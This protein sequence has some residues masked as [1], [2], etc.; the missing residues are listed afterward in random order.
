MRRL[1]ELL[2]YF[3]PYRGR[4]AAGVAAILA[5]AALGLA[6]PALL[7]AAIDALASR[8]TGATLLAYGAILVGVAV[9][10]GVFS[11]LQRRIL[12]GVSRDIEYD[13]RND[14]F[15]HLERLDAD[16][17]R[18]N[19]IGD[20]MARSTSDLGA[21]RMLCG[22][23]IMYGTHTV[24]TAIGALAGMVWI[25]PPLTLVAVA[26]LPVVALV[27]QVFGERIHHLFETAQREFATLTARAQENLAGV[28][29][30]RAYAR[31][32]SERA[33]FAERNADY[34]G[35]NLR[36]ARWQA[37]FNPALQG[38]VGLGF[39]AVLGFGGARVISGALTV[40]ELVTFHFF[41]GKLVWP[42]IAVGWV[43][44]LAQRAAASWGRLTA[45][46]DRESAIFDAPD[47]FDPGEIRGG[48]RF[49]GLTLRH[50]EGAPP[51]LA[52]LRLDLPA[53]ST[54]GVVGRTGAGKSTLLSL[55]PRLVD[56]PPGT[57]FIDGVDVRRI[58][59][60][61]L[62]AAIAMVPQESFLFSASIAE[63]VA[64]GRPGASRA[65]IEEAVRLAGLDVDLSGF[66]RGLE[67]RVGERGVTLSGGQR[68]RVALARALLRRPRILLL[69][70]CLS[71]L[72]ARTEARVLDNVRQ[73]LPG[74]TVVI[75]AH[76]V[77]TVEDADLI[78][79]LEQGEI[80][81]RGTHAEL[82]ARGGRY[83]ALARMQ[84]LEE[85]L[86]VA[87]G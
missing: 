18:T 73:V 15:A 37:A 19:R 17:Y 47:A 35:A 82:L 56:P 23:A 4:V 36:L 40:G 48:V 5:A 12:V 42:M 6:A 81:E 63:N 39:A 59:L 1:R 69:D 38:L 80:V 29:V 83:A 60:A 75:V 71:A 70:D 76:R 24:A 61:R 14:Y 85:E 53:G 66:P 41:L 45:I 8:P 44:N 20:L 7:G 33:A 22:P 77:S 13:L 52:D 50:R 31:E 58:R 28:R 11:F 10:Q 64:L 25:D 72:D 2:P 79:V 74:R 51:A 30:V 21:V 26:A 65:E 16:F 68:Q 3:R 32:K 78:V 55:L 27:T 62:R 54:V 86:A 87:A 49:A 67:T 84:R 43:I 34:V 46:L 57:L 9:V